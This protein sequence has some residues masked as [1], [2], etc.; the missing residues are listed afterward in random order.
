MKKRIELSVFLAMLLFLSSGCATVRHAV[1]HDLVTKAQIEGMSDIRSFAGEE[2]SVI[3]KSLIESV[4]EEKPDDYP[5]DKDGVKTYP[6]LALSGGAANGAYGAG[7]L[8]GWSE[9]GSRP[10]F[11]VVTGVS[12]GAL[13]AV[14]AFL[15]PEYDEALE[16]LYTTMSTKDVMTG[17]GPI[18]I[19]LGDSLASDRPF[20]RQITLLM[21]DDLVKRIADEHKKGRR[22]FVGT[23]YLDAQKFVVWDM[24][25]I[26]SYGTPESKKLFRKVLLASASIPVT[27]PPVIFKVNANGNVYD[28]MH[29]DGGTITQVFALYG[30][31]SGLSGA[32]RAAGLINI[33]MSKYK[34]KTYIIRNG[35]MSSRYQ[36]TKDDL[37]SISSRAFDT[38]IDAQAGGDTYRLYTFAKEK[39]ADFNLAYIPNDLIPQNKELFDTKEMKRIFARGYKDAKEG[40]QWCKEPPGLKHVVGNA[41]R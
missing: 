34:S 24:G 31:T 38:L 37:L 3:E 20:V 17:K 39:G 40:Y 15:G 36:P 28:E 6:I 9:N 32:A 16:K 13:I 11:K 33:D 35:W 27:F 2:N 30:L 25:A 14:L 8:K 12:T 29:V 19:L 23:A 7:F 5:V 22:L 26:A 1:P 21:T 41:Y 18:R 4:K 10:K